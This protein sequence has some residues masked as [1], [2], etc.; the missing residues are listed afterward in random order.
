MR[1]LSKKFLAITWALL[2]VFV[3]VFAQAGPS[4]EMYS[5]ALKLSSRGAHAEAVQK[6]WDLVQSF[7][8]DPLVD[9]ALFQ[10]GSLN[11]RFIG[12]F[13]E[14]VKAYTLLQERFPNSKPALRARTRL[15]RLE[16]KRQTGDEP[17][18]IFK[19]IL[20]QYASIGSEE[21][22]ARARKLYQEFPS[23]SER[24]HVLFWIAEE[25][26]RQRDY[27][28]ALEDYKLLLRDYPKSKWSSFATSKMGRTYVELREFEAAVTAF[29]R[30]IEY[31]SLHPGARETS[32][33]EIKT[34]ALFQRFQ[35]LNILCL[36]IICA[37]L[38]IWLPGIRWRAL[39]AQ[40]VKGALVD[41]GILSGIF[42]AGA[43]L[44]SS[45]PMFYASTLIVTWVAVATA[46]LLNHLFHS[47][48]TLSMAGRILTTVG[49]M[50]A[51]TA[52]IYAVYYRMDMVNLLYHSIQYSM[53]HSK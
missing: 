10:I 50:I 24:D 19:Q 43:L 26:F 38:L 34:V 36:V 14:A 21:S 7:P 12:N 6:L 15:S 18:R 4:Q 11:E 52:I 28:K 46:G 2:F 49:A 29:E 3:P 48:R 23:F 1:K 42:L 45:K 37:A 17:L 35:R 33:E 53:E 9:D 22:L 8:Q 40:N 47:T 39:S 5:Q 41:A 32:E 44:I 25:E 31:E 20:N 13:D 51:V 30:L 16:K 27:E